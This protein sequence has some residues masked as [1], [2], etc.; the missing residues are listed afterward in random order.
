MRLFPDGSFDAYVQL[1]PGENLLRVTVHGE[2]G[3]TREIERTVRYEKIPDSALARAR[4]QDLL[5]EIRLR[6]L[7]TQLAEEARRKRAK[8]KARQLEIRTER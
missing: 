3:G 8:A 1:R 2:S 4:L 5:D 7:E 6:T